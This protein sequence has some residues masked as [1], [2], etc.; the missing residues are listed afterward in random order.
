MQRDFSH[1]AIVGLRGTGGDEEFQG[2]LAEYLWHPCR[3]NKKPFAALEFQTANATADAEKR[4]LWCRGA[5][6]DAESPAFPR[7]TRKAASEA[8]KTYEPDD[9]ETDD[10]YLLSKVQARGTAFMPLFAKTR[11][12][13][14]QSLGMTERDRERLERQAPDAAARREN[15]RAARAEAVS[16]LWAGVACSTDASSDGTSSSSESRESL[17]ADAGEVAQRDAATPLCAD[18]GNVA[19]TLRLP[20]TSSNGVSL[21]N[22][23]ARSIR[24]TMLIDTAFSCACPQS[25][26]EL[27]GRKAE[28]SHRPNGMANNSVGDVGAICP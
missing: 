25:A 3:D 21:Q 27:T 2:R 5:S 28:G 7:M 10:E 4:G 24:Y 22:Q 18:A 6:A 23:T 14:N 16:A 1:C 15:A 8:R 26:Q 19:Q 11:Q 13:W 12:Q 9:V 20:A 17:C